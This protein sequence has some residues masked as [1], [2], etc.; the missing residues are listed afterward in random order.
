[1]FFPCSPSL[2]LF[3]SPCPPFHTVAHYIAHSNIH[4]WTWHWF[5]VPHIQEGPT[6]RLLDVSSLLIGWQEYLSTN[7]FSF[8]MASQPFWLHSD[9]FWL[10]LTM[11]MILFV[12]KYLVFHG[13]YQIFQGWRVVFPWLRST[14]LTDLLTSWWRISHTESTIVSG[15]CHHKCNYHIISSHQSHHPVNDHNRSWPTE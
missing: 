4:P 3:F 14:Q 8:A 5:Q 1:M 15:I 6:E 7:G 2:A 11:G 13:G 9:Y 10:F 12:P